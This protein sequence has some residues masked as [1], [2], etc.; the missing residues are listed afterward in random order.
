[1]ISPDKVAQSI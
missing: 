1:V